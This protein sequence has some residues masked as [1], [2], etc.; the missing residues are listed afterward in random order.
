MQLG[1]P[2]PLCAFNDHNGCVGHVHTHLDDRG[3]YHD[4]G[5]ALYKTFHFVILVGRLHFTVHNGNLILGLWKI[6]Y[7]AF[8]PIHQI[9]VIQCF[10][11]LDQWVNDINLS[12]FF[13]FI[14]DEPKDLQAIAIESVHR[15]NGFSARRQLIDH[16]NIQVAVQAHGQGSRDRSGRHHQYVGGRLVFVPKL[17]ALCHTKSV[18]FVH[19]GQTKVFKLHLILQHGVG[20]YQNVQIAIFQLIVDQSTFGFFSGTRQQGNLY[21]HVLQKF[22]ETIVVLRG[23]NFCWCHQTGLETVINGQEHAHK[24]NNRLAGTHIPLQ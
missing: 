5:F 21:I 1:K 9:L 4:L 8:V 19:N 11:F 6:T 15:F 17:G 20:A 23:Q 2:E 7:Y 10:G 16:R 22:L 13:Y 24:G 3:G 18:L 14:F 12:S